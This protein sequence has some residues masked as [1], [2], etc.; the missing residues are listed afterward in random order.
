MYC[1]QVL[2]GPP[3]TLIRPVLYAVDIESVCRCADLRQ[4]R[5]ALAGLDDSAQARAEVEQ[6]SILHRRACRDPGEVF[7]ALYSRRYAQAQRNGTNSREE[8]GFK[9][10]IEVKAY[11]S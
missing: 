7:L 4:H 10:V 3:S 11:M 9:G 5:Y 8:T 2:A 1:W 6:F